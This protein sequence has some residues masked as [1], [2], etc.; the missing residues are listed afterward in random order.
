[1]ENRKKRRLSSTNDI[2][3]SK[4][5]ETTQS[6]TVRTKNRLDND[7]K[8][9]IQTRYSLR[10]CKH[11]TSK[12]KSN[13]NKGSNNNRIKRRIALNELQNLKQPKQLKADDELIQPST[14]TAVEDIVIDTKYVTYRKISLEK[15]S[16]SLLNSRTFSIET[17]QTKQLKISESFTQPGRSVEPIVIDTKH[18]TFRDVNLQNFEKESPSD[19][20]NYK[21]FSN[22]NLYYKDLTTVSNT[23]G[24]SPIECDDTPYFDDTKSSAISVTTKRYSETDPLF[25]ERRR[26]WKCS[27]FKDERNIKNDRKTDELIIVDGIPSLKRKTFKKD[28]IFSKEPG[29]IDLD[30]NK[31]T[32]KFHNFTFILINSSR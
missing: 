14:S 6:T 5:K 17:Q 18:V 2:S 32:R 3:E 7:D 25:L 4:T 30:S 24:I 1:M 8:E 20:L 31:S 13:D 16:Q 11:S 29:I 19:L 15:K 28:L 27:P 9:N 22:E 21:T 12:T 26:L 10:S 23:I